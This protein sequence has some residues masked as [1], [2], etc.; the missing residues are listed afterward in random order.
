MKTLYLIRHDKVAVPTGLC[1]GQTDV[2]LAASPVNLAANLRAQL[3]ISYALFCS[4]LSRCRLLAEQLGQPI[5]D[6]RFMEIH[7]GDWEERMFADTPRSQ[8]DAWAANPLHFRMPGGESVAAMQARVL[9]ALG[10]AIVCAADDIV[11]VSHGGP[12]RAMLG[13][14]QKIPPLEWMQKAIDYGS[15]T[16]L[17]L[18]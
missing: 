14:I 10:D 2:P 18:P 7:F 17:E 6:T 5:E 3:P 8:I 16:V 15:L 1:Y 12:I 11:I 9:A 4:P 13:H